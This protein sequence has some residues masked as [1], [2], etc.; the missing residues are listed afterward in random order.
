MNNIFRNQKL[1]AVILATILAAPV[2]GFIMGFVRC[3]DCGWNILWRVFVGLVF[4]ALT[5]IFAGFPP[6]NE[7]GVGTRLN[8]WPYIS[9]T[10]IGL[11]AFLYLRIRRRKKTAEDIRKS[12]YQ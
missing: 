12:G 5:P 8:A 4:A 10:W 11:M 6:A 7:A 3:T 9:L 1:K 2:G